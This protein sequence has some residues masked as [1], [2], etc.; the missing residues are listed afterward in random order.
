[1]PRPQHTAAATRYITCKKKRKD[2]D[3]FMLNRTKT[4]QTQDS[5]TYLIDSNRFVFFSFRF[6]WKMSMIE[7]AEFFGIIVRIL[8]VGL[9]N[10]YLIKKGPS[11]VNQPAQTQR[12]KREKP[13]QQ[14][15][16]FDL[17]QVKAHYFQV[18]FFHFNFLNKLLLFQVFRVFEF[19]S[20]AL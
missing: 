1:M 10:F 11:T 12:G 19:R 13:N 4:N 16:F 8:L 14:V 15:S 17:L 6:R 3:F 18:F 5:T 20:T 2:I 9:R 7:S